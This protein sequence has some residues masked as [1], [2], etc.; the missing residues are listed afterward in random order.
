MWASKF[1]VRLK[2][3]IQHVA[4]IE[5]QITKWQQHNFNVDYVFPILYL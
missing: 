1:V 3:Y 4:Y 5:S 2:K